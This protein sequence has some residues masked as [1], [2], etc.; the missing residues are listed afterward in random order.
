VWLKSPNFTAKINLVKKEHFKGLDSLRFFAALAVFF[1]HVELIKKFTGFGT[2]WIDPEERI[3]KFTVFQ[4][5][6]SKEIDP[7]SPL[8]AYSSALGVVFFFVLSGF[9]ITYLLLK[10][11]QSNNSI[12]LG[13]FY[14]RRALR[15]WP[16]YYLIFI[17][18]FFVLPYVD[19]FAV[20]GQD[21]FFQQNFWG[22]LLLYAC[23]M[24]NLAFAIYTTAVPNIGQSWSIGVEEQFYLLWPL[25]IRKSKNVLKSIL[26]I[27]G[28]II[29]LKGLILLSAPF[30]KIESLIVLKKFLA[31][32]KLECMALGG[33]GAYFL[34]HKKE[35]LLHIIYKPLSQILSVIMIPIL[36]YFIPTALEDILHLLFSISFLVIILNVAG[37]EKS[38]LKFENRVLQYLGRISYG[39][40]MFHV[41]C[42]VFTIHTLDKYIGLNNDI[43][44]PQHILLYGISFLLSVAVSSLSYHIFEMA[45]IRLKDKYAQPKLTTE[46]AQEDV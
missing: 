10:E 23:F 16:L 44:T 27:A 18:G 20:P 26:W 30:V 1:T 29:T 21:N 13:K 24:P 5:V 4:S 25:L 43:T 33:L 28:T 42:I 6:I 34:F 12:A 2:H 45:F 19:F 38:L 15:I 39:F 41:M 14:I 35:Q 46:T 7:I 36:I 40:Y 9:L 32:S 17:L 22:N 8:I 37:N 3:T 31:M 11:K